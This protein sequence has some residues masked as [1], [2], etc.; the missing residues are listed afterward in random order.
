[1]FTGLVE[2]V[3]TL[4]ASQ[5]ARAEV[6]RR[7]TIR[8][9]LGD[10]PARVGDSVAVEGCCLTVVPG[11]EE[12]AEL[13]FEATTETLERTSLGTLTVGSRVNLERSLRLGDRLG[14][15]LVSGHV[16]A[17]GEVVAV[18]PRDSAVYLTVRAPAALQ[19][20]ITPRGSITLAGVSLTVTAAAPPT[21]AVALIP[22]TLAH[23]TLGERQ[24]GDRLNIEV[25]LLARYVDNLLQK[26]PPRPG[27]P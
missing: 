14:G 10:A 8:C 4:R 24:P 12:P 3:G 19:R 9:D 15:H 23:T 21:F 2:K 25:D 11:T 13:C 6:P 5:Q 16:D 22:H 1:M 18:E 26:T 27:Q 17:V 7:L 20:F